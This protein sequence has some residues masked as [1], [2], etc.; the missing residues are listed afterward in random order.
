M[1]TL[2]VLAVENTPYGKRRTSMIPPEPSAVLE[3]SLHSRQ[4]FWYYIYEYWQINSTQQR[5]RGE[6][7]K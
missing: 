4:S 2:Y 1:M 3:E 6:R 7:S 5:L